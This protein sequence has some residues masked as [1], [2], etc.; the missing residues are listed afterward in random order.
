MSEIIKGFTDGDQFRRANQYNE[1]QKRFERWGLTPEME[2]VTPTVGINIAHLIQMKSVKKLR[3]EIV[4][5][6]LSAT[7]L[8]ISTAEGPKDFQKLLKWLGAGHVS[9]IAIDISDGI[10][11]EIRRTKLDEIT[12]LL[13]D[14]RNTGLYATAKIL[15]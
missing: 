13:R 9:T 15:I 7:I 12:C 3:E 5:Q 4:G 2:K 10:F 6:P 1:N 14:A 8:G 11:D